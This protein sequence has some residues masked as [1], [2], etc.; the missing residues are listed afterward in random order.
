MASRSPSRDDQSSMQ[1]HAGHG[2]SHSLDLG[3]GKDEAIPDVGSHHK[4]RDF[5]AQ[6]TWSSPF[7]TP[8]GAYGDREVGRP[9]DNRSDRP[10]VHY[11]DGSFVGTAPTRID[12]R[13]STVS[14]ADF[15]SVR[16]RSTV[17]SGNFKTVDDFQDFDVGGPGW[18]RT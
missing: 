15:P 9:N 8:E 10:H 5:A 17:R 1:N 6:G 18:H 14:T 2:R 11:P 12:T 3:G 16:R 7:M 13:S 4:V